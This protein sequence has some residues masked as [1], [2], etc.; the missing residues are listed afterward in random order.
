MRSSQPPRGWSR[1]NLRG[2]HEPLPQ[3]AGSESPSLGCSNAPSSS[4]RVSFGVEET[5]YLVRDLPHTGVERLRANLHEHVPHV[6]DQE[7]LS[8]VTG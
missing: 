6:L 8:L 5:H 1:N 4:R 7:Q 2:D 3:Y